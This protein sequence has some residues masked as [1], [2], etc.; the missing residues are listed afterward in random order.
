MANR[1]L[2]GIVDRKAN[3]FA[4]QPQMF[5]N[6]TVAIRHFDDV[7]KHEQPNAV[8]S[9]KEDHD[10]VIFGEFNEDTMEFAP[11]NEIL[12]TGAQWIAQNTK[13]EA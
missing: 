2:I 10:L 11:R 9:H 1:L 12:Q 3:D 8:N 7:M 13:G 4:G 6:A 5:R